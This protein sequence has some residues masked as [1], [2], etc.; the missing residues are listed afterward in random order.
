MTRV[1]RVAMSFVQSST[2]TPNPWERFLLATAIPTA[3]LRH[4]CGLSPF[5][6]HV[7]VVPPPCHCTPQNVHG[8]HVGAAA[9]LAA[10]PT[11]ALALAADAMVGCCGW[12]WGSVIF[13]I[14]GRAGAQM[15]GQSGCRIL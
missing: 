8:F 9:A 14:V 2:R 10:A 11:P 7:V 4:V 1:Y 3:L 6:M 13:G 15:V 5:A 12:K